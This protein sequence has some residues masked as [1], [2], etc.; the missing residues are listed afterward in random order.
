MKINPIGIGPSVLG[1]SGGLG[2]P[3][4]Q[5]LAPPVITASTASEK[6]GETFQEIAGRYDLHAITPRQFDEL[7][8]ELRNGGHLPDDALEELAAVRLEIQRAQLD[9]DEPIDLIELFH[10]KLATLL[11]RLAQSQLGGEEEE[12]AVEPAAVRA[13]RRQLAW[14][15]RLDTARSGKGEHRLDEIV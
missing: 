7:I 6:P 10:D 2:D 5:R 9:P 11:E 14:L 13:V 8:Q 1:P 4:S 3:V 12:P 15:E